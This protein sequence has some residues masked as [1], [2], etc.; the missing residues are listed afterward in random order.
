MSVGPI[1]SLVL[2][3]NLS[4]AAFAYAW[5]GVFM[6]AFFAVGFAVPVAGIFFS[7]IRWCI[8]HRKAVFPGQAEW[9]G[10]YETDSARVFRRGDGVEAAPEYALHFS[11]AE[12]M[13]S[14]DDAWRIQLPEE[15]ARTWRTHRTQTQRRADPGIDYKGVLNGLPTT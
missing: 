11:H 15:R 2:Y 1:F 8:S 12:D 3:H 13:R 4:P 10:E 6:S 14:P 7:N 9:I 5:V